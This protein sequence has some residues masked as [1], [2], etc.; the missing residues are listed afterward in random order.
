M[1]D[2]GEV[3]DNAYPPY[4]RCDIQKIEGGT[5]PAPKDCDGEWGRS[6]NINKDAAQGE[7]ICVGDAVFDETYPVL[8]YGQTWQKDGF[9]CLSE[10]SGISCFN[11]HRHGFTLS[12]ASRKLF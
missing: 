7:L 2:N 9:T 5:P 12:K 4:V 8:Q 11:A 1:Y 6:F 10:E 3:S